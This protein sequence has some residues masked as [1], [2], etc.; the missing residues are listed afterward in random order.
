MKALGELPVQWRRYVPATGEDQESRSR[1][2]VADQGRSHR[3][4]WEEGG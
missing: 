3:Q 2:E 1:W 4:V